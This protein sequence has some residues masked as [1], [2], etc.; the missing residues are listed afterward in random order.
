MAKVTSVLLF[1]T[2]ALAGIA[3]PRHSAGHAINESLAT[4]TRDLMPAACTSGQSA[5]KQRPAGYPIT[6]YT[7][8]T[9]DA[10]NW[11]SYAIKP[12]WYGD[13]FVSGPHVSLIL[14]LPPF[15]SLELVVFL[16]LISYADNDAGTGHELQPQER[17]VRSLQVPVHLQRRCQ[18]QRVLCVVWYVTR[19]SSS[20]ICA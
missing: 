7:M 15:S 6:D 10:A 1:A 8:V 11:T 4:P 3:A 5:S 12:D 18:L 13:H 16:W 20:T 17:P 2:S 9:A 14:C 19:F